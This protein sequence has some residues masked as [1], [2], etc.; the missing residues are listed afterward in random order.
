MSRAREWG[1]LCPEDGKLL[2]E[3]KGTDKLHCPNN[4]H[5]GR[6]KTHPLGAA[7][8]TPA[9]FDRDQVKEGYAIVANDAPSGTGLTAAQIKRMQAAG[10]TD[11][12][13]DAAAEK[14]VNDKPKR[15]AAVKEGRDC[16]CG[17][18]DKPKGGRFLPGHDAKLHSRLKKER[19]AELNAAEAAKG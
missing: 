15:V 8:P 18:G 1:F 12:A 9:F 13:S 11:T 19:E 17:C 2:I 5:N 10:K 16:E 4:A 14:A 6:P 7:D 3:L